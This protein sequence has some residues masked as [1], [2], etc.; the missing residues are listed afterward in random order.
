[1]L[2]SIYNVLQCGM[3]CKNMFNLVYRSKSQSLMTFPNLFVHLYENRSGTKY[4]LTSFHR[5]TC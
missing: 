3:V 1:M 5:T 2:S 4:N